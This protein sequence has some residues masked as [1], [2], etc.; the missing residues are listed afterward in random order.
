MDVLYRKLAAV[1]NDKS[2]FESI[3]H[4][5]KIMLQAPQRWKE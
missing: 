2:Y 5:Y 4:K 1:Y 3:F